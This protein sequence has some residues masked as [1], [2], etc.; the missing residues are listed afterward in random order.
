[1]KWQIVYDEKNKIVRV[2]VEGIIMAKETAKMAIQGIKFAREINCNKF[3]I[4]YL[5]TRVGDSIVDTYQFMEGLEK[6]GITYK[7][8]IALVYSKDRESHHFAETV[9]INRGWIN[10]KY[11]QNEMNEAIQW[12]VDRNP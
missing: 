8:S 11:F 3:L 6:L 9:A 4:D 1:M 12:L 2:T 10:I 5:H 7:D